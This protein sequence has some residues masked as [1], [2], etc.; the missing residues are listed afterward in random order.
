[1][2]DMNNRCTIDECLCTSNVTGECHCDNHTHKNHTQSRLG[3]KVMR[4]DG[5]IS[6]RDNTEATRDS[7]R[8]GMQK[9]HEEGSFIH[10]RLLI[11]RLSPVVGKWGS[12]VSLRKQLNA[13]LGIDLKTK[14]VLSSSSLVHEPNGYEVEYEDS[15]SFG[16][17]IGLVSDLI[18]STPAPYNIDMNQEQQR[19]QQWLQQQIL[20]RNQQQ[21][22]QQ[23]LE[24]QYQQMLQEKELVQVYQDDDTYSI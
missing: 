3:T 1:M 24:Q 12:I 2:T 7:T 11:L 13:H 4:D 21:Q 5:T 6:S 20:D 16:R 22:Q 19:E 18:E 8:K 15:D 17:Q 10:K 9:L 23:I 14:W